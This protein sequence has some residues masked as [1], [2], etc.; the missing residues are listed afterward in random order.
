MIVFLIPVRHEAG[1]N[2]YDKIWRLLNHTLT[3]IAAQDCPDWHV[4]VCAN[5]VLP[6]L[7]SL[8]SN[9]ITFLENKRDFLG[10]TL[11]AWDFHDFRDHLRDKA[12]RRRCGVMYT[13]EHIRAPKWYFMADADDYVSSDLVSTILETTEPHHL[14]TTVECG[15]IVNVG[16]N[17]YS[18]TD[19]FNTA[20]G[21][22][23]A[24]RADLVHHS[25]SSSLDIGI[26][27]GQHKYDQYFTDICKRCEHHKLEGIPRAAYLQHDQNHGRKI[28]DYTK[29]M[30]DAK[31][32]SDEIRAQFS[33]PLT[34]GLTNDEPEL[35]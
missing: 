7:P 31:P 19:D 28:W 14:I 34:F 35:E 27:L 13:L 18:V 32:I 6:I 17:L 25:L 4:V 24:I 33:I 23:I 11:N 12:Y 26:C 3:S 1:V 16:R 15:L 30:E 22:S 5:T 20:C 21:T 2:D 9:K 29:Q 8:P 10:R